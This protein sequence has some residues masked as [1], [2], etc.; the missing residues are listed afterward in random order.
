[1]LLYITRRVGVALLALLVISMI[2]FG[3]LKVSGNLA[4]SLAGEGN[5][6]AYAEFVTKQYGLDRPLPVQYASWLG[7]TLSGDF[8]RSFYFDD[9]VAHLV[10]QRLPVTLTLGV[11][12]MVG[13][14]LFSFP[15]GVLAALWRD[16]LLDRFAQF[17]ALIGQAMPIFW[18]GFL[19]MM[20]FGIELGWL[21]VSG[22]GSADH[23]VLPATVLAV[24]AMPAMLRLVRSSMLE[25]LDTDYVRTAR[26]KGLR[27]RTVVLKHAL[28]NALVPVVALAAV[29][30]GFVL[31]G[32]V[33]AET[34]FALQG[35]GDLT[36]QAIMQND[37]PVV[38]AT[39]LLISAFY[40]GLTLVADL[41]NMLIDPRLRLKTQ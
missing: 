19:L 20:L 39:V 28:R 17:L 4:I 36:R 38:Q 26:A 41:L 23:Y 31:S 37:Y 7:R 13:A 22:S 40:V 8:G 21:P 16:S 5:S 27:R 12:A 2:S 34:V 18:L 6:A 1:V 3:L 9:S 35:V 11:M 29:Q 14:L 15:L 32:S 30:F 25:V 10:D 33:V 24:Y